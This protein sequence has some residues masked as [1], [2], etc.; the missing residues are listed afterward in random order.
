MTLSIVLLADV[1]SEEISGELRNLLMD[2]VAVYPIRAPEHSVSPSY[3]LYLFSPGLSPSA[4]TL[5]VAQAMEGVLKAPAVTLFCL[6][7]QRAGAAFSPE[8]K[9]ALRM[10]ERRILVNG[11]KSF[12]SLQSV[13]D[14]V[15]YW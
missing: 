7:E 12:S 10:V 8:V 9:E 4:L 15:N 5:A 14:Y 11:G 6:L 2:D 13:A 1:F 3:H